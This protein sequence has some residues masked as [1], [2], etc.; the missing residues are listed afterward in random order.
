M[1]TS[2]RERPK[3]ILNNKYNDVYDGQYS[4]RYNTVTLVTKTDGTNHILQNLDN[5]GPDGIDWATAHE[6]DHWI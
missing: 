2:I 6:L 4:P 5:K 1:T 3:L